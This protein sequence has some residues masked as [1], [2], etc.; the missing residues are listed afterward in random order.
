MPI[1][2][3]GRVLVI[4]GA[5]SGIGAATAVACAKAGLDAVLNGRDAGRLAQVAAA[6]RQVG[7]AAEIVVGDVTDPGLSAKLLD[8]ATQRFGR[9]DVV[10]AN[11]GYGFKIGRAHV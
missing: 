10:F 6:V 8:A 5:S 9:F 7:R 1:D 11:A 4:T 2:L 3:T